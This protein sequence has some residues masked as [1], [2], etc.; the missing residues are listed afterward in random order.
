MHVAVVDVGG[1]LSPGSATGTQWRRMFGSGRRPGWVY[2]PSLM[3]ILEPGARTVPGFGRCLIT[4]P[5]FA[6]TPPF[7]VTLPILQS[8]LRE[9]LL[10]ALSLSP[11]RRGTM[12]CTVSVEVEP[13]SGPNGEG[14]AT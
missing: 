4:L 3:L 12:Q 7:S 13:P 6:V 11:L 2:R 5:D 14:E 10:D 9:R 8:A 1:R